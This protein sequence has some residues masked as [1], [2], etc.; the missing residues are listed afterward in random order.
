MAV[1][2]F[3]PLGFAFGT[4]IDPVFKVL[5]N[6]AG[7]WSVSDDETLKIE[8]LRISNI[9]EEGPTKEYK[10]GKDNK[11][12]I[13]YGK[14]YKI[15]MEDVIGS[16]TIFETLFGAKSESN[17]FSFGTT[18][19]NTRYQIEGNTFVIDRETGKK[20]NVKITFYNFLPEEQLSLSLEA[21]GDFATLN[22]SG[23]ISPSK[24]EDTEGLV[25][26]IESIEEVA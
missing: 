11:T 19:K 1:K 4:V 10:G 7:V 26:S 15:T 9:E 25:Y 17:G 6:T 2:A 3:N 22:M 24:V 20:Q 13:K 18:Y 8:S 12:K 23:E 21:D 16:K 14:T 5:V